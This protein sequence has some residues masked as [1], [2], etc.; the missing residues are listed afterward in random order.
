MHA[1]STSEA[2]LIARLRCDAP[3]RS[4]F[5]IP[6]LGT[7]YSASSQADQSPVHGSIALVLRPSVRRIVVDAALVFQ[8]LLGA[9]ARP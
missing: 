7:A 2:A 3:C 5:S 6:I 1:P 9:L 8:P 4:R